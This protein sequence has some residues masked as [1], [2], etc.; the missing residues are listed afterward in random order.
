MS[1]VIG[2]QQPSFQVLSDDLIKCPQ[3]NEEK[4]G[5]VKACD[6]EDETFACSGN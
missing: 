4:K 5:I 1:S 3:E 2:K 6:L